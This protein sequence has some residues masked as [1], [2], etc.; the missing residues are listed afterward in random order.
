MKT[1]TLVMSMLL[2][3][4][5]VTK[6]GSGTV[7]DLSP[8]LRDALVRDAAC[9]KNST[10]DAAASTDLLQSPVDTLE[11]HSAA[12]SNLGVIAAFTGGCHCQGVNCATYVYLKT[13]GSFKLAFTGSFASLHPMKVSRNGYPSLT[14]KLQV[15]DARAET[16][17]YDWNGKNYHP[18]LC[19]TVTQGQNQKRPSIVRHACSGESRPQ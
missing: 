15:S 3:A 19:A 14:A 12:R 13:A 16:T 7:A 5:A 9:S 11:I 1:R 8:E 6:G 10:P 18:S 17:V 4:S 2:L